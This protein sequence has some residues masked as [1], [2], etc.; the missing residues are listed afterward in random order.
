MHRGDQVE[1]QLGEVGELLA[2]EGLGHEVREDQPNAAQTSIRAAHAI[3][4]GQLEAV[5][6][7]ED[8]ALTRPRRSMNKPIRR[9][10]SWA[11]S[12]RSRASAGLIT[13]GGPDAARQASASCAN[14]ARLEVRGVAVDGHVVG[15]VEDLERDRERLLSASS[16]AAS[17]RRASCCAP[18]R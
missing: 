3:E 1:A 6:V 7:P 2:V 10:S 18:V 8:D 14:V 15:S 5:S 16:A 11:S 9:L 4:L 12:S 13:I 17:L